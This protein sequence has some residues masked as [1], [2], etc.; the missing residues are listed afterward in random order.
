MKT[1]SFTAAMICAT[2]VAGCA[3]VPMTPAT[4]DL[5]AKR[6]QP[7]SDQ[8]NIYISRSG[9]L[10]GAGVVIQM[11]LDGRVSGY[12]A[13]STYMLLSVKPGK[14]MISTGFGTENIEQLRIDAEPGQ[15]YFVMADLGF[16]WVQ[17]HVYMHQIDAA[18]GQ[19]EVASS[20]RAE[21]TTYE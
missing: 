17:P 20:K 4:L 18:V 1:C 9:Q 7:A 21:G 14:H 12:L 6:F 13:S 10:A 11:L 2:I 19:K 16:G 15:N 3:T 5:E 8:A